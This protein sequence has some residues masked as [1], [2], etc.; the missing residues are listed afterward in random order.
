MWVDN[1]KLNIG[2]ERIE[3]WGV[4][5][6]RDKWRALVHAVMNFRIP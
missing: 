3:Y 4:A 2:V 5:E 6:Y 1:I